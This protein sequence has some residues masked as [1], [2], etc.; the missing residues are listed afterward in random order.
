MVMPEGNSPKFPADLNE[1]TIAFK[2][3]SDTCRY[4]YDNRI[5]LFVQRND[6][7]VKPAGE[8][9]GGFVEKNMTVGSGYITT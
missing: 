1:G 4:A 7:S 2:S 6:G 9:T 5:K 3:D 8:I